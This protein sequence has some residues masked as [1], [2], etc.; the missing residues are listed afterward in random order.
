MPPRPQV[1]LGQQ[2]S[3][4]LDLERTSPDTAAAALLVVLARGEGRVVTVAEAARAVRRVCGS[5]S[6][7]L[8]RV[9]V[10]QLEEMWQVGAVGGMWGGGQSDRRVDEV[11]RAGREEE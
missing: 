3:P 2:L 1:E 11:G 5:A 6:Y 10:R 7:D 4:A 9:Q 8:V